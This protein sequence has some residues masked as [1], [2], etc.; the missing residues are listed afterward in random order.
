M[1]L[2]VEHVLLSVRESAEATLFDARLQ[3]GH[4]A[5][6]RPQVC[7]PGLPARDVAFG[8]SSHQ[9]FR[10]GEATRVTCSKVEG[11]ARRK[12]AALV[13]L[14]ERVQARTAEDAGASSRASAR[15]SE[16]GK[17]RVRVANKYTVRVD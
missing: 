17:Q 4:N 13:R 11:G 15:P 12:R 1:D 9:S 2:D 3:R 8:S 14:A 6:R 5:C 10:R 16:R 7:Q